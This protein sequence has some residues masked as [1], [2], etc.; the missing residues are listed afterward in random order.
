MHLWCVARNTSCPHHFL[1]HPVVKN[2]FTW[3][4]WGSG[5][6]EKRVLCCAEHGGGRK[7]QDGGREA[8]KTQVMQGLAQKKGQCYKKCRD[9]LRRI[10]L[11]NRP[12]HGRHK[13][14][15]PVS[16]P[17]N[18]YVSLFSNNPNSAFRG[19]ISES[20]SLEGTTW[21]LTFQ[22]KGF[23]RY[24]QKPE[25]ACIIQLSPVVTLGHA[26]SLC[27]VPGPNKPHPF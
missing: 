26:P 5:E 10:C 27:I 14:R 25:I 20:H 3:A 21:E 23:G 8:G 9:R 1:T 13:P 6:A 2:L 22:Q 19:C 15:F 24:R 17:F 11:Q 12:D 16:L 18:Y 4:Q 7:R